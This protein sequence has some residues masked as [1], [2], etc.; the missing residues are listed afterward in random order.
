MAA[1]NVA[2]LQQPCLPTGTVPGTR[3]HPGAITASRGP[4][5]VTRFNARAKS[6]AYARP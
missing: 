3:N 5:S 2:S 1:Q 4:G 6:P